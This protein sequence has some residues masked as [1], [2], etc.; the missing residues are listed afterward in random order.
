MPLLSR[1]LGYKIS[2]NFGYNYYGHFVW[3]DFESGMGDPRR[4]V[5]RVC[6]QWKHEIV[7]APVEKD[8]AC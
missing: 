7:D 6:R 8:S 1:I 3:V 5:Y 2:D 4:R